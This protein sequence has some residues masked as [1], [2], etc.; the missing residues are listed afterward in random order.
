MYF[1]LDL[2]GRLDSKG[3]IL[4]YRGKEAIQK[5][6]LLFFLTKPGDFV[7]SDFGGILDRLLFKKM[8]ENSL[9]KF[10]FMIKNSIYNKFSPA[11]TVQSLELLPD[12]INGIL[13]LSLKYVIN[14]TGEN[15]KVVAY[16][17]TPK[18]DAEFM[19][20]I[21]VYLVGKQLFETFVIV[22]KMKQPDKLL[23]YNR[24]KNLWQWGNFDLI[25]FNDSDEYFQTIFDYINK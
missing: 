15:D 4:Q 25:N 7:R 24:P 9:R 13:E 18:N 14:E 19:K 12:E 10:E 1:D 16:Y 3:K 6:V 5:A 2:Y 20:R 22:Q 11:I 17:N 21:P 23:I 8:D